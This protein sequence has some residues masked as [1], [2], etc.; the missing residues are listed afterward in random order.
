M[1][2]FVPKTRWG[3][4]FAILG[5]I[6]LL[7]IIVSAVQGRNTTNAGASVS[8]VS[9]SSTPATSATPASAVKKAH[10]H[11]VEFVVTG[12]PADVTYGHGGST[13]HGTVPMHL[14]KALNG[15]AT[16][17]TLTAVLG[18]GGHVTVKIL[19]DG[20]VI[21]KATGEG[22]YQSADVVITKNP[23]TDQWENALGE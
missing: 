12:S 22:L 15:G 5:G 20:K 4:F 18:N 21:A 23:F 14:T 8:P 17:Y 6:T 10:G 3:K 9:N 11:T 2:R 1:K 19:V 13:S 7:L 16:D